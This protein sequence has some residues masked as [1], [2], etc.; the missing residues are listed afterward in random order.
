[1]LNFLLEPDHAAVERFAEA[2]SDL[3]FGQG[4]DGGKGPFQRIC[5]VILT[6]RNVFFQYALGMIL[7]LQILRFI[8]DN[9]RW[10]QAM[11]NNVQRHPHDTILSTQK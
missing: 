2:G 11:R 7:I 6:S 9:R 1:M 3:F 10:I 5:I 4:V 8:F